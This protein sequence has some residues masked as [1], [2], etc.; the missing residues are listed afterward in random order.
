M[1]GFERRMLY[2]TSI[3]PIFLHSIGLGRG[4]VDQRS[5]RGGSSYLNEDPRDRLY[6]SGNRVAEYSM[7]IRGNGRDGYW[8]VRGQ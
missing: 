3:E 7:F 8:Q 5:I 1:L 6:Q 2:Y 4:Q